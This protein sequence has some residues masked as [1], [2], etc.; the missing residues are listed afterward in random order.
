MPFDYLFSDGDVYSA[1]SGYF[2]KHSDCSLE[3]KHDKSKYSTYYS[4]VEINDIADGEFIEQGENIGRIQLDPAKSNCK[5]DWPQKSFL[6]ATGPHLHLE[7]RYDGRPASLQGRIISNLRINTG[8]LPHDMYCSDPEDCTSATYE[9]K[10]CAT[11]YTDLTTGHVICP[12][13]K[14]SN[15]GK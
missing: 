7:L 6:C 10:A 9:G 13:T 2:K 3:L 1:H 15:M 8:L 14:G 12:V 11:T 4:H 5:C